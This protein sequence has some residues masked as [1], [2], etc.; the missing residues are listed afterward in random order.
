MHICKCQLHLIKFHT[1]K[2]ITFLN[3]FIILHD[4]FC[5]ISKLLIKI[6]YIKRYIYFITKFCKLLLVFSRLLNNE[7]NR[8]KVNVFIKLTKL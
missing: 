6:Y 5:F 3:I 7:I 4:T 1:Q 8:D 2:S